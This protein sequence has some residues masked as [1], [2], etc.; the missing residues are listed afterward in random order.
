MKF[1]LLLSILIAALGLPA[2]TAVNLTV[3]ANTSYQNIDGF[4][5]N[6]NTAWWNDGEVKPAIDLLVDNLNAR[7]FRAVIEEMDW[8]AVNDDA[9]PGHFNWT[10][11]NAIYSNAK[12]QKSGTLC[13]TSIKKEF[14][15]ASSS[16]LWVSRR[17]GWAETPLFPAPWKTSLSRRWFRFFIT[18][19]I[20]SASSSS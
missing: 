4:G 8:E 3:N 1:P 17:T 9:N 11:Y 14:P 20:P 19:E 10:A 5:V 7:L 6:V 18:R 12:F 13:V 16:V 2:A 15:M